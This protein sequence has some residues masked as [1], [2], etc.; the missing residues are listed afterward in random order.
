MPWLAQ[1]HYYDDQHQPSPSI[2]PNSPVLVDIS[3]TAYPTYLHHEPSDR[4][5]T[6][7]RCIT[8]PFVHILHI[9]QPSHTSKL[10]SMT[11]CVSIGKS[12]SPAAKLQKNFLTPYPPPP[13]PHRPETPHGGKASW[14]PQGCE[15]QREPRILLILTDTPAQRDR[16]QSSN[17]TQILP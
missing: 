7:A 4:S 13:P 15:L 9:Q 14:S 10:P 6:V 11:L 12:S 17:D 3:L 2:K 1:T 5:I 8:P 16:Y